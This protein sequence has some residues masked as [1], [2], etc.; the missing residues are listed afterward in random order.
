MKKINIETVNILKL[1]IL[2]VISLLFSILMAFVTSILVSQ[3]IELN[4]L[5]Y[6]FFAFYFIFLKILNK[7]AYSNVEISMSGNEIII[8]NSNIEFSFTP[9]DVRKYRIQQKYTNFP[10]FKVETFDN[11]VFKFNSK[12][13]YSQDY[14]DF[15]NHFQLIIS[16]Y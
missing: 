5:F 3:L 9:K 1:Y 4:F 11:R 8:T 12:N 14:E 10:S 2:G 6:L 16:T 15:I 13:K 7:Y